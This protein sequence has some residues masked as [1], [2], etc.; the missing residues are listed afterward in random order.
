MTFFTKRS[1]DSMNRHFDAP[2]F[3]RFLLEF[4]HRGQPKALKQGLLP[5]VIIYLFFS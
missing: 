5:N 3:M 4:H 1:P 2:D